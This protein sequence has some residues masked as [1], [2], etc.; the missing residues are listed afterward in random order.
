MLLFFQSNA[1]VEQY[2]PTKTGRPGRLGQKPELAPGAEIGTPGVAA[3]M[4]VTEMNAL[5]EYVQGSPGVRQSLQELLRGNASLQAQQSA[6][7]FPINDLKRAIQRSV[8]KENTVVFRGTSNPDILNAKLGDVI[9]EKGF[10]STSKEYA[11]AERFAGKFPEPNGTFKNTVVRIQLPKGTNGLDV[12]STYNDFSEVSVPGYEKSGLKFDNSFKVEQ[13]VLLPPGTQFEVVNVI[14]GQPPTKDY[15]AIPSV[16]TLRAIVKEPLAPSAK[17][18]DVLNEATLKLQ[19]DM[20]DA[21]NAGKLVEY[22]DSTGRWKKVKSID[23]E[24]LV[25]A[26]DTDEAEVVLFKNWSNRPVFRVGYSKGKVEPYRV[27]GKPLYMTKWEDI[28]LELREADFGGKKSNYRTWIKSKEYGLNLPKG[29]WM[30]SMK[31]NNEDIWNDVK[32]GKVKGTQIFPCCTISIRH[33]LI[34]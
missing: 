32:A 1:C 17:R 23:Y 25:L 5:E 11:V 10:T 24:T 16:F 29:T 31:V 19:S 33:D 2:I 26:A 4:P 30:I 22:K 13:E 8:I 21:V 7:K 28:P 6:S 12:N 9:T 34:G 15:P 3:Q 18:S 14:E 27:Y 20:I